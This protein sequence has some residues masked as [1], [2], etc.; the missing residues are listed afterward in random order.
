MRSASRSIGFSQKIALPALRRLLDQIGVHVGRRADRDRV[1]LR[2]GDDLVD[3]GDGSARRLGERLGRGRIGVGDEPDLAVRACGDVGRVNL[4]DA[5]RADDAKPH[6]FLPTA[7]PA[8]RLFP[9][10]TRPEKKE[11]TFHIVF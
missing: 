2:G 10:Q 9:R 1:D 6:A 5:P 7:D 3:R 4:A 8:D 11:Y